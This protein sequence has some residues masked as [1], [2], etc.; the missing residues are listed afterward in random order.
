MGN[1]ARLAR[2]AVAM[3]RLSA[4]AVMAL[5]LLARLPA[6]AATCPSPKDLQMAEVDRA[7]VQERHIEG[8]SK[9]LVSRGELHADA[10]RIIWHMKD[11]FDVKT[12]ITSDGITES[13]SG[14]P[15]QP[16]GAGSGELGASV[17]RSAAALMR[18]QWD[19]LSSLFNVS[20]PSS[21]IATDGPDI[22]CFT[23]PSKKN[24]PR[25]TS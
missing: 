25:W 18:G 10:E 23:S 20:S 21:T 7:F 14:G 4:F 8:L 24:L 15:A 13:V 3:A 11:P 5:L 22:R 2:E 9:P 6:E 17:A 16:V 1:A 19:E 12:V